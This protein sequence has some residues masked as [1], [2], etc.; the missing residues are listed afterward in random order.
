MAVGKDLSKSSQVTS[1]ASSGGPLDC[2]LCCA[3]EIQFDGVKR[4]IPDKRILH[5]LLTSRKAD[6]WAGVVLAYVL[7]S[8]NMASE[9]FI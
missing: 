7:L 2:V 8:R 6:S 5:A 4:A 3:V 1:R 9:Y